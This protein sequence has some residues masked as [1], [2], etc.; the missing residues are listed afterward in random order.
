MGL[1]KKLELHYYVVFTVNG[2]EETLRVL[3]FQNKINYSDSGYYNGNA[4]AFLD[5]AYDALAQAPAAI[6]EGF[7]A[8]FDA[9]GNWISGNQDQNK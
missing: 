4:E 5:E 2:L 9:L 8:A 7:V 3:C 6:G 1:R